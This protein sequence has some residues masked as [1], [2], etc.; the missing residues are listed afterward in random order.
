MWRRGISKDEFEA[1][2]IYFVLAVDSAVDAK[3]RGNVVMARF[4]RFV[5][6]LLDD[7]VLSKI[8]E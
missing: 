3:R 2:V 8:N 5:A 6:E 4:W 7:H 1:G